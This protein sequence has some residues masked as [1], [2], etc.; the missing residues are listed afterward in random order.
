MHFHTLVAIHQ[1]HHNM[2]CR[3]STVGSL[4]YVPISSYP[5]SIVPGGDQVFK[6]CDVDFEPSYFKIVDF[7]E[8]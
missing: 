8:V 5:P 7:L 2:L 3:L 1:S 6:S 4:P